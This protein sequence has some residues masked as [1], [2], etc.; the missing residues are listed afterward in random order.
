MERI[1]D[2]TKKKNWIDG[3]TF[4][5]KIENHSK[6]YNGR[7]LILIKSVNDIW[8]CNFESTSDFEKEMRNSPLFYIK[9]TNGKQI[10]NNFEELNKLDYIKT[11]VIYTD[12][13]TKNRFDK[14]LY[15][16]AD[17][18]NYTYE[19]LYNLLFHREFDY[20]NFVY[21]GNYKFDSPKNEFIPNRCIQLPGEWTKFDWVETLLNDYEDYNLRKSSH[22]TEEG[23][24]KYASTYKSNIGFVEGAM[25]FAKESVKKAKEIYLY[26]IGPKLYDAEDAL[27]IRDDY[28]KF[29]RK[30][31]KNNQSNADMIQELCD[32]YEDY[33]NDS[34]EGPLFWIILADLQMKK[35]Q[36]TEEQKEKALESIEKDLNN[37]KD[38]EGYFERK[39]ELDVLKEKLVNYRFGNR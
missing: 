31:K 7:Y 11:W 33:I 38:K 15:D 23:A 25:A 29:S 1:I 9:I 35:K 22:F 36:L 14:G 6:E 4:A 17:E 37:W 12:E 3:D 13:T 28:N 2:K 19:Y 30:S 24:K 32:Y 18:F 16:E 21:I 34:I 39:S 20:D 27:Y 10:P 26:G 8:K 5:V